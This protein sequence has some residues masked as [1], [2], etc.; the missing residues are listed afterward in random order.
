MAERLL[1]DRAVTA[2]NLLETLV[3]QRNETLERLGPLLLDYGVP[4]DHIAANVTWVD[5]WS[6]EDSTRHQHF[7]DYFAALP[8]RVP[9]LATVAA[10]GLAQ[11]EASLKEAEDRERAARV[12]GA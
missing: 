2:D 8:A 12:R 5:S 3:G 6:G 10:A 11:Q 4:P 1:H 7:I 9:A